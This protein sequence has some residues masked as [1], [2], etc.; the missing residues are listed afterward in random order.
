MLKQNA[1]MDAYVLK[2][3]SLDCGSKLGYLKA[4]VEYGIKDMKLGG[5]FQD[6]IKSVAA[7]C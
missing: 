5:E 1:E 6:Y 3:R 7:K 4:I 2:G